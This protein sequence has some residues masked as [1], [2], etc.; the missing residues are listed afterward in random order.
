MISI[1]TKAIAGIALLAIVP[2]DVQAQ[3]SR[4]AE[5][6]ARLQQLE[7]AVV[8]LR[9]ELEAARTQAAE[10]RAQV[11]AAESEVAA[12]DMRPASPAAAP[13]APTAA[14][15]G[16]GSGATTINIGGYIKTVVTFSRWDDGVVAANS[17]GRDFYLPSAIPV[18]G[19]RESID[20]D[21]SAKQTRL[22]LN[23]STD[24]SGRLLKGYIEADFQTAPGIQASE[25]TTN[26]YNLA[27][28]RAFM[29]YGKLTIGQDW[30]TFQ[31]VAVLPESVDFVGP[32]EG[33]VFVRQPLVRVSLPIASGTTLHVSA[34]NAETASSSL[35]TPAL[36][37]NDDDRLPDF[38]ARLA[39]SGGWGEASLAGLVR[40]LSVESGAGSDQGT[41]WGISGATKVLFGAAKQHDL[42]MMATY[43]S[44]IGRY[45]G[46][47]F[48]PDAVLQPASTTI[49]TPNVFA[50][51]MAV[52]IRLTPQL[53]TSV[54]GGLQEVGYP[55]RLSTFG[56]SN[57]NERAWSLAGN[58]FYTLASGFDIGVEYRR[59]E[60]ILVNGESGQLDR[61]EFGAKY[62]F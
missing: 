48:A 21:F 60:R 42:R 38:A 24:V 4:E 45:V 10:S 49:E 1:K 14:S 46:L 6:E 7:A 54:M 52:R 61:L 3:T 37:E 29:Q 16:F 13:A 57:F 43:G 58:L 25:R 18:G 53:R 41:G 8:D 62:T 30:T 40:Q 47:N 55:D 12:V 36:V 17:L 50:A 15:S 22:W 34:E 32:T 33:T 56:L 5:L 51:L 20:N 44:G 59:G 28:R 26:G 31:N 39:Y 9:S 23:L 27:L 35:G 11:E 2:T 19:I